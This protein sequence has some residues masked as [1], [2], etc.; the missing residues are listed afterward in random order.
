MLSPKALVNLYSDLQARPQPHIRLPVRFFMGSLAE[1][2]LLLLL[3]SAC[4]YSVMY[5]VS[6]FLWLYVPFLAILFGKIWVLYGLSL[7][8]LYVTIGIFYAVTIPLGPWLRHLF[9]A[10]FTLL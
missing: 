8:R 3:A 7:P 5:I 1:F 10:L 6:V 4:G 2:F 9:T